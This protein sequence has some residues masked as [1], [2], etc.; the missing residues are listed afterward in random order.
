MFIP[1]PGQREVSQYKCGKMGI[2]AVPGSGKTQTLSYLASNLIAGNLLDEDQEIL[3]VTLVNSA[4]NNFSARISGFLEELGLIPGI[5]YRVR[6]LHGL[7]YDIVRE[8]PHL[9]GLENHFSIADERTSNDIL[10]RNAVGWVRSHKD[11]LAKLSPDDIFSSSDTNNWVRLIQTISSNFIRLSKDHLQSPE[12]LQSKLSKISEND[13]LLS[14][15]I[16]TYHDYSKTLRDR[17]SVDFDDLIWLAFRMLSENPDYL[18]RLQHRWP[19][20]L[21]DEAQDSS[22]IQQKMLAL[23]S[24][25]SNN[26]VR[27]GDPNQAIF[28]TFT[29]ADPTLLRLFVNQPNVRSVD[30]PH[31]G[32]STKSIIT[33]ANH[34]VKW[35]AS[36][37]P[38]NELRHALS[39][40]LIEPTPAGDPQPNPT[41]KPDK[42]I[43]H[44]QAL[45]PEKEI[46]I[47]A[48][49][50]GKWITEH[51]QKTAAILVP[52]NSR[53]TK[54]VEK[55]TQLK[56]PTVELLSTSKKTRDAA[57]VFKDILHFYSFPT[58]RRYLTRAFLTTSQIKF[59]QVDSNNKL[60]HIKEILDQLSQPEKIF[61]QTGGIDFFLSLSDFNEDEQRIIAF[62]IE[63][64]S[65]WQR[66]VL[67]PIDEMVITIGAELFED[68]ADLAL[69]HK[70]AMVLKR[71]LS[72]YP[73]YQLPE[74]CVEL[75]A[76]VNN[77]Y[78]LFGFTD[79]DLG[80]DPDA[81][82]GEVVVSTIHKSKGLEWDRVYL[83]S[84]NNYNFPS[85]EQSDTYISE[86]WFV[87]DHRNL[88]A[89]TVAK[90][91]ALLNDEPTLEQSAL[92]LA[93][94]SARIGYCAERLRLLYVGITRAREELIFTWNTG[95]RK[96]STEAY[97]VKMLRNFQE[98]IYASDQ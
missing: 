40:P 96:D 27:V 4:V 7:A 33:I 3:I 95:R 26:W 13:N 72:F 15:S 48:K 36:E 93:S 31:S 79:E 78:R 66:A 1:R 47:V 98:G 11:A 82:K 88:E 19:F 46:E 43:F 67:L 52:R 65:K 25:N 23:L 60:K 21:E 63:K 37:H 85:L 32:R 76:I 53:G 2:T 51:P 90:L 77:R 28:E 34:L 57:S 84:V 30:L 71:S 64:M 54:L 20:I 44:D 92:S 8:Q 70:I 6:T 59:K 50:A 89:E 10:A 87:K 81:H 61:S 14:M 49:S 86:K 56:I 55:L 24:A 9:V 17:G 97:P 75:E 16:Q 18:Q 12:N 22:R 5:G 58:I 39:A 74:F 80:F 38:R 35:T 69:T 41:D 91:N 73:E 45:S 29:T 83:V 42:V 68:Q 94:H 62:V